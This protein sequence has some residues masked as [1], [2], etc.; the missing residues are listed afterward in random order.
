MKTASGIRFL[1]LNLQPEVRKLHVNHWLLASFA[2]IMLASFLPQMQAYMFGE[3]LHL[4]EAVHGRTAGMLNFWQEIVIIA[5]MAV[6]GP[7]SDQFGRKVFMAGGFAVMAVGTALHPYSS[8]VGEL[9][10]YRCIFAAGMAAVTVVMVTLM[11]DYISN[12]SRGKAAGFQGMMNGF[13]A[14]VAVFLLLRLP[15]LFQRDGATPIEAGTQTYFIGA[16]IALAFAVLM[17]FGL[18]PGRPAAAVAAKQPF[19]ELARAGYQ[20]AARDPRIAL[21]YAAS[22]IARGNLAIVGTFL[23]LWGANYGTSVLGLVRSEALAKAG[24]LV[25]MAQGMALL[26]APLFGILADKIDRVRALAIALLCSGIGYGST[27]FVD[28]PFGGLMIFSAIFIGLG[29]VGCIITS[30]V[31]I[32]Q[33]SPEASRGAIIGTFNLVGA[34][35]ILVASVVGGWLFDHWRAPGPFV[36]FGVLALVVMVAAVMLQARERTRA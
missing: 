5:A 30:G 4:P 10:L 34:V 7:L 32:S 21:A 28:N 9:L 17:W 3:F 35:G 25:G 22:F 8:S 19:G 27:F 29:E 23:A 12:E 36:F 13:G 15:A 14:M 1:G 20:A 31:L 11:A 26:G 16:A 18:K 33:Q 24:A 2:G 6:I